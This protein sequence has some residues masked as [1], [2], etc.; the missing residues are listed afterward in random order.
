MMA[1]YVLMVRGSRI[2]AHA[3]LHVV[4]C[5]DAVCPIYYA[6]QSFRQDIAFNTI[7][8]HTI[9]ADQA[10]VDA[11]VPND[12]VPCPVCLEYIS[13]TLINAHL[14]NCLLA[15][16]K[17][18]VLR[19]APYVCPYVKL[20]LFSSLIHYIYDC[21]ISFLRSAFMFKLSQT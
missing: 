9:Q 14:D 16:E 2:P 21:F 17:R 18:A 7:P 8:Y 5:I 13:S 10:S 1:C 6:N 15:S 20:C 4:I 11:P 12:T 3:Y 19:K